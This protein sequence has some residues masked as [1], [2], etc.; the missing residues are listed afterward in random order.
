MIEN[1]RSLAVLA[2]VVKEG[3]FRGAGA[4]LG[5]SPSV[6]SHHISN[7]EE[8]LD[9]ALLYRTSRKLKLTQ[10]GAILHRAAREMV[11]T[12]AL[13]LEAISETDGQP[14]GSLRIAVPHV[15]SS[16]VFT[17]ILQDYMA[18]Y[19]KVNIEL[20]L[21]SETVHPVND[22][23]D[24]VLSSQPL[25]EKSLESRAL[26]HIKIGAFAAPDLAKTLLDV[27]LIDALHQCPFILSPGFT[28]QDWSDVFSTV[29]AL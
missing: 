14:N 10:K 29:E 6:V 8:R 22:G 27:R 5:L 13:G 2:A 11:D 24:L 26:A 21:I 23:F 7:L 9:C 19:P 12:V 1:L 25:E 18:A 28:A 3:S 16:S 17:R 4:K 15:A 20:T